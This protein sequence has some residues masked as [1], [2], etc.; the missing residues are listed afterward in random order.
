MLKNSCIIKSSKEFEISPYSPEE[1]LNCCWTSETENNQWH[2]IKNTT[3]PLPMKDSWSIFDGPVVNLRSSS[4]MSPGQSS[5]ISLAWT[6]L[7]QALYLQ[8]RHWRP[9]C[10]KPLSNSL[11]FLHRVGLV[12]R[13][14]WMR[15]ECGTF[16]LDWITYS[17]CSGLPIVAEP[18][19]TL[20]LCLIIIFIF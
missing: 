3:S 11:H 2:F 8:S 20:G 4:G 16:G 5:P 7:L 10:R 9:C 19:L 17:I 13:Y 12:G 18:P 1:R 6:Q 15:N 14:V